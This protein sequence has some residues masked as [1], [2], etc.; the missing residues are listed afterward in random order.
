MLLI[1]TNQV[2]KIDE[3]IELEAGREV[4]SI[5]VSEPI[6]MVRNI[7]KHQPSSLVRE[8]SSS[9]SSSEKVSRESKATLDSSP[10]LM[11]DAS[12]NATSL[13]NSK[14]EEADAPG[15]VEEDCVSGKSKAGPQ[16]KVFTLTRITQR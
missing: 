8:L 3:V 6:I 5:R 15:Q 2:Q 10:S 12:I 7:V 9:D 1:S 16:E 11:E 4:F 14:N 13:G